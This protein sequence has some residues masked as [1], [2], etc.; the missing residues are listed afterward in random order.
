MDGVVYGLTVTYR[1]PEPITHSIEYWCSDTH[2]F[3]SAH[4]RWEVV[5]ALRKHDPE[6]KFVVRDTLSPT[7]AIVLQQIESA[8]S[9]SWVD[10]R[11]T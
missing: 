2:L 7:P 8:L 5:E 1:H 11:S 9:K 10:T 4:A 6:I 3:T